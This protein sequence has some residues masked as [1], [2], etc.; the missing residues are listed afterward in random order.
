MK[1]VIYLLVGIFLISSIQA[2]SWSGGTINIINQTI[3]GGGVGNLSQLEDVNL[4]GVSNEDVL[5]FNSTSSI[6]FPSP[7]N[8]DI[9]LISTSHL[10]SQADGSNGD[11]NRNL[12]VFS[13]T[14][15]VYLDGL[16]LI[17]GTD[18]SFGGT[19]IEFL[20]PLYDTQNIISWRETNPNTFNS[21]IFDGSNASLN[22]GD[23]NRQLNVG[24]DLIMVYVDGLQMFEDLDYTYN[25]I[26]ATFL[27]PIYD[28]QKITVWSI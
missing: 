10:G 12:T 8:T 19:N 3:G 26:N 27:N 1:K 25:N 11:S 4:S 16:Q 24:N 6:W 17:N 14:I 21:T 7:G 2:I 22:D 18:Y 13:N 15:M 20:I 9:S 23:I 28:T 5:T